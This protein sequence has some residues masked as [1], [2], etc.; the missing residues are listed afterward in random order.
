MRVDKE[1]TRTGI[2]LLDSQHDQYFTAVESLLELVEHGGASAR[3]VGE[4]MSHIQEYAVENFDTEEYIM[5]NSNYPRQA[6]HEAKHSAFKD[7]ID[8]FTQQLEEGVDSNEL[9]TQLA[10]LLVN[11]FVNQ[12]K[13]DDMQLVAFM[14]KHDIRPGHR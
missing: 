5:D 12:I 7:R 6:E 10:S 11:W 14:N 2:P 9:S 13:E 4:I 8:H 1:T 3:Q